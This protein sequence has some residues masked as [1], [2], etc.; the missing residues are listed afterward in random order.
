VSQSHRNTRRGAKA[1]QYGLML[2]LALFFLL[3]L[4]FMF[5]SAFKSDELQLLADMGSLRALLPVGTLS[6]HNFE[7]V[8]ENSGFVRALVNSLLVVSVT[9]LLGL[10][11]NSML[12]FA[13]ARLQFRGRNLVLG[14]VIALIIVPFEA[15]AVPLL[16]LVNQLPWWADG[17]LARGWLDSYQVQVIPFIANAFS[18]YLFYQFFIGLP[19]DLEEAALVDGAN[20]W[21]IYW[22]VV[23]PIS[24]PAIATVAVLQFLARWGDLLWPVMTVRGDQFATLPLAM[25]TFFGQFPRHWGEVMA[26]AMLATLPTLLVFIVCQRWFVKS[27]VSSAIKG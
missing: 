20:W 9:V 21:Q 25:Q 3:P 8:I 17:G 19:K 26:Y 13:L 10:L 11:V 2:L 14:L 7:R 12:A 4:A 15:V 5:V 24:G 18:V 22:R 16:M 1:L 27:A 6:L 23:L